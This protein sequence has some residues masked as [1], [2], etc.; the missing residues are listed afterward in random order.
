M[1]RYSAERGLLALPD[2]YWDQ[3]FSPACEAVIRQYAPKIGDQAAAPVVVGSAAFQAT[4]AARAYFA[5]S[6]KK[7]LGNG[8]QGEP[9]TKAPPPDET[10]EGTVKP[11]DVRD[12]IFGGAQ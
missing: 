1:A 9:A 6:K 3:V 7:T 8:A 2:M 10:P 5:E 4:Q 12:V 11:R